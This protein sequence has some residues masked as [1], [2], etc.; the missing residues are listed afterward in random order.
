MT[1]CADDKQTAGIQ[2]FLLLDLH[3]GRNFVALG[4]SVGELFTR[5][6]LPVDS[7]S[8]LAALLDLWGLA[9]DGVDGKFDCAESARLG[10]KC[11]VG[12][13]SWDTLV[14]FNRPVL[15]TL[16]DTRGR[17]AS[18]VL[19]SVAGDRATLLAGKHP[20]VTERAALTPL[21][22]GEYLMLWRPPAVYRRLLSSGAQGQDVAWLKDRLAEIFGEPR[23]EVQDAIF[24]AALRDK[25]IAFQESRGLAADGI[26]GTRTLIHLNTAAKESGV[27]LLQPT[28]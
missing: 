11:L 6:A 7:E 16:K 8:A 28:A 13:A 4:L 24:D 2:C 23:A 9:Q 26:V 10:V 5:G 15:I 1:F 20:V 19:A 25:V 21:W 12:E 22:S 3:L 17:R 18:V 27:P 14:G